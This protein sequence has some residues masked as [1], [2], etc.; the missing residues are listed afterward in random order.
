[1]RYFVLFTHRSGSS[2]LCDLL[3]SIGLGQPDEYN[4]WQQPTPERL[5]QAFAQQGKVA[6]VKVAWDVFNALATKGCQLE[7]MGKLIWLT[8]EDKLAQAIS[9]ARAIQTDQWSS[10]DKPEREPCFDRELIAKQLTLIIRHEELWRAYLANKHALHLTY[11]QPDERKLS[12]ICEHL[13]FEPVGSPVS[14][15]TKQADELSEQWRQQWL[16]GSGEV[17]QL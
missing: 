16:H 9:W 7:R 17:V 1:M 3:A 15:F 2:H 6:G 5:K 11:E 12:L 8:R 13:E 4:L 14:H 10:F